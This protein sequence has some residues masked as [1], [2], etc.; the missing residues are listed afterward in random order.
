MPLYVYR[1][2]FEIASTVY[3]E[4]I[5]PPHTDG[6]KTNSFS[7]IKSI[8]LFCPGFPKLVFTTLLFGELKSVTKIKLFPL[9]S[10]K[11]VFES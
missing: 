11:E 9:L 2:T 1:N 6:D 10:N 4:K 8:Q 7:G 3:L 5:Y